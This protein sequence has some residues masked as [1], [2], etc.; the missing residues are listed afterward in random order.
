MSG[1]TG[2]KPLLSGVHLSV[3]SLIF[4]LHI[5]VEVIHTKDGMMVFEVGLKGRCD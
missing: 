3:R 2:Q 4:I 1:R 5:D